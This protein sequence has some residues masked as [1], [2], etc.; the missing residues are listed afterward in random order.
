MSNQTLVLENLSKPGIL[1][2]ISFEIN[3]GERVGLIGESG[4]GKT[5]TALSVLR[6]VDST[7]EIRLSDQNIRELSERGMCEIRGKK[8]AMVFQEPLS[9][10]DPLMRVEQQIAGVLTVHGARAQDAKRRVPDLLTQV[11]LDPEHA[12]RF[13]HELSGGQ[14]QRVLIAMA[15]ANEPDL[16]I[17]DEPTTALDVTSQRDIVEL[18]LNLVARRDTSLLFITH[19]LGLIAHTCERIVVLK[20]GAVV[21]T[22][23][24]EKILT[25]PTH[26]YTQQLIEASILPPARPHPH[27]TDVQIDVASVSKTFRRRF[28]RTTTAVRDVSLQVTK[29]ERLGVVGGSGSGKTTLLRMISG[30]TSPTSGSIKV[31]GTTRMVFQDPRGSLDPRMSIREI[32]AE[33]SINA[34]PSDA[35]LIAAVEEVGLPANILDRY[36][37]EFSGGQRQRI[38]IARAV[39]GQP[40]ILLADE[41]VSALDVSVRKKVLALLDHLVEQKQLS[42]VF[43]SHDLHVVRSVCS[44]VAV[45]RQGE[46]VEY[47]PTEE[48]FNNPKHPYTVQLLDAAPRIPQAKNL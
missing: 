9:A 21:E 16:L 27:G 32:L 3:L 47:G 31:A 1:H 33:G 34:S 4:S 28:G 46:I 25:T 26:P 12:R 10:L 30:L 13:P 17:C 29:G 48:I 44:T 2:N 7:G 43:V 5:M 14:R 35:E 24:T 11:G 38:S 15:L 8:V 40:E 6:L 45:M 39:L 36:P 18:V 22:G 41:P 42:M 19:D 20:D 23:T 37:H